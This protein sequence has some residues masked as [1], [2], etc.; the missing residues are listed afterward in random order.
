M[1][2]L[3]QFV[4][5]L[6]LIGF[7]GAYFGWIAAIAAVAALVWIARQAFRSIDSIEAEDAQRAQAEARRRAAVAARADQQHAWVMARDDRG[8]YGLYPPAAI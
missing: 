4:G 2:T 1:R 7:V 6:L 3:R 8:V 5:V